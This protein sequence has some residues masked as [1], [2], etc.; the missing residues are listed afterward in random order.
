M[1][2]IIVFAA[3]AA[4]A[5]CTAAEQTPPTADA[6]APAPATAAELL[7]ALPGRMRDAGTVSFTSARVGETDR[8][9]S[10]GVLRWD[11]SGVDLRWQHGGS[12]TVLLDDV[13]YDKLPPTVSVTL[14]EG[15]TWVRTRQGGQDQYSRG[16]EP[17]WTVAPDM[18]SPT[19]G[20][21]HKIDAVTLASRTSQPEGRTEYVLEHDDDVY[22]L[23][24]DPGGLPSHLAVDHAAQD[25]SPV[26]DTTTFDGW[27]D[28]VTIEAPPADLTCDA[29]QV[30]F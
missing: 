16:M 2:V 13:L 8:P 29:D 17:M 9:E 5:G 10:S 4:L 15:R 22:R 3:V 11:D 14:P 19:R 24:L 18:L 6:P 26:T 25:G 12:T 21:E 20:L 27:G 23:T 30:K 7:G 28:A 1:R